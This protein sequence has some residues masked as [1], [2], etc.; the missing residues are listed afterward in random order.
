MIYRILIVEDEPPS[1]RRIERCI[2]QSGVT[3]VMIAGKA[4]NGAEALE[5]IPSIRPHIILSDV[6]MPVMDGFA[7]V[8]EVRRQYPLICIAMLSGYQEFDYVRKALQFQLTDYLLKPLNIDELASVLNKMKDTLFH[9]IHQAVDQYLRECI[10]HYATS[11]ILP[12]ELSSYHVFVFNQGWYYNGSFSYQLITPLDRDLCVLPAA[13]TE[14]ADHCWMLECGPPNQLL[15]VLGFV[16]PPEISPSWPEYLETFAQQK[17]L[18][19]AGHLGASPSQLSAAVNNCRKWIASALIPDRGHFLD[20]RL[21]LP[22]HP[23]SVLSKGDEKNLLAPLEAGDLH[24]FSRTLSAI[25]QQQLPP[26]STQSAIYS[27]LDSILLSLRTYLFGLSDDRL[28]TLDLMLRELLLCTPAEQLRE[29]FVS[30][31]HRFLLSCD[32]LYGSSSS[33]D[34]ILH[35]IA[36]YLHQNYRE[37]VELQTLACSFGISPTYL[38]TLFKKQYGMTPMKYLVSIRVERAK[39]L[40]CSHPDIPL[41][42]VAQ[43]V[44]YEDPH[45]FSRIFRITTGLSPSEFRAASHLKTDQKDGAL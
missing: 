28:Q 16:R 26:G 20:A 18:T 3:D 5:L 41:R 32:C 7:L 19:I 33:T 27:L 2:L 36:S 12:D 31:V 14:Q 11:A 21:P 25:L 15:Y 9:S 43:L 17:Q 22:H 4:Y 44:G 23:A 34:M 37:Q 42:D 1:M 39:E 40:I 13:L 8:E 24:R 30:R 45:Y 38:S 10:G 29:G 35:Q 6:R